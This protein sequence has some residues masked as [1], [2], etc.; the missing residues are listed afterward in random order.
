MSFK[1]LKAS[2]K[3]FISKVENFKGA[4]IMI[5]MVIIAIGIVIVGSMLM[6]T[7]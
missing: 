1:L 7:G 2:P 5:P 4:R 6:E 3:A